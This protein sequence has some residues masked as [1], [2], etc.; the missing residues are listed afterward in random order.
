[1][2]KD[3]EIKNEEIISEFW[4]L[5]SWDWLVQF[6]QIWYVDLPSLEAF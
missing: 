5:V 6:A 4:S 3:D 1:V 2:Q